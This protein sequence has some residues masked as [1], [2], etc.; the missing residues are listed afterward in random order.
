MA[1]LEDFTQATVINIDFSD[2]LKVE[3]SPSLEK[4]IYQFIF[5]QATGV[6]VSSETAERASRGYPGDL[7]NEI[8]KFNEEQGQQSN[9]HY[10]LLFDEIGVLQDLADDTSNFSD[11][12]SALSKICTSAPNDTVIKKDEQIH[13]IY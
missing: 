10:L 9:G 7:F 11:V 4:L 3:T 2:I 6:V 13:A 5:A 12:K 1:N 8:K